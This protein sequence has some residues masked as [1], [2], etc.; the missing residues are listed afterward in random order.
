MPT[1]GVMGRVELGQNIFVD[2]SSKIG[3]FDAHGERPNLQSLIT[4][5]S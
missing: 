4:G 1:M 2:N 3:L 5:V